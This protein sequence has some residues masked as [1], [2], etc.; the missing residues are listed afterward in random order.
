MIRGVHTSPITD[1]VWSSDGLFATVSTTAGPGMKDIC[2]IEVVQSNGE[3]VPP[4][5]ESPFGNLHRLNFATSKFAQKGQR[6]QNTVRG[7]SRTAS[8]P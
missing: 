6:E 7:P 8:F 4:T 2:K 1:A 3:Y 5:R